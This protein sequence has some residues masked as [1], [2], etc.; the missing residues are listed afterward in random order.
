MFVY[1][2]YLKLVIEFKLESIVGTYH[3]YLLII[4]IINNIKLYD[5]NKLSPSPLDYVGNHNLNEIN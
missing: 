2:C 1:S 5:A 4:I 3:T